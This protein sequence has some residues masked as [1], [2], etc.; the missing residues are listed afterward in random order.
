[1]TPKKT[2]G[3]WNPKEWPVYFIAADGGTLRSAAP[4]AD[5]L[6]IAMDRLESPGDLKI[7]EKFFDDGKSV[8]VDSGVF[9]LSNRHA[10]AHGLSMDQALSLAPDKVDGF[11]DL[12]ERYVTIAKKWADK[13]WGFI[14]IDQGGRD[15]KIKT[16]AK[17][18]AIGL[19]PIPVYHPMNDGLDYFDYLAKRYDR[20]CFGNV[21]LAD[22]ATRKRLIATAWERRRRYPH[23]WIH[24]LGMTPSETTTAFPI[25]SCDSSTWIAGVRWGVHKTLI[26]N[27][28]PSELGIEFLYVQEQGGWDPRGHEKSRLMSGW[29]AYVVG[30]TMRQMAND[31][32]RELGADPGM[33]K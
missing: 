15:N 31:Q 3:R 14:E 23:L 10:E 22:Q 7:I 29:D 6:L 33:F 24:A 9:E 4:V 1:M 20:I 30:R 5:H 12:F 13:A 26:A 17:L 28:S 21:V 2:G 18:E 11:K 32:R 19:R 27:G 8:L 16:R 25:N